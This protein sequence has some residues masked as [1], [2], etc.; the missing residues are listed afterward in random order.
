MSLDEEEET[1]G[2]RAV[3]ETAEVLGVE[4]AELDYI[5]PELAAEAAVELE[6]DMAELDEEEGEIQ[7]LVTPPNRISYMSHIV[8]GFGGTPHWTFYLNC[9]YGTRYILR[10]DQINRWETAGHCRTPNGSYVPRY[11]VWWHT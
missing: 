5:T 6:P 11:K 10:S 8:A 4:P 1:P 2:D 3:R 9:Q 7:A